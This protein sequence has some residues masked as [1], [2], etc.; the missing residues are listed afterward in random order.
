[1]KRSALDA[2]EANSLAAKPVA[3]RPRDA[4]SLIILDRSPSGVRVLLG[5]RRADLK[6]MPGQFV[7]P[8][9]RTDA[10]DRFTGVAGQLP[11]DDL[12]KLI[13]GQGSGA[14]A[15]RSH[16]I[17]VT[18]LRE[19]YEETGLM[20]GRPAQAGIATAIYGGHG[21]APD[22]STL[23]YLARAITPPGRVRRF[24]TRFFA[25]WRDSIGGER[26]GGAPDQEFS[27]LRWASFAETA[28]LDCPAITRTIL[29]VIEARLIVDPL[30]TDVVAV[31]EYRMRHGRFVCEM[32]D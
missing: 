13:A 4:A 14:S 25:V 28:N 8:G 31:P 29:S 17:G 7:F 5:K 24:D 2:L 11:A 18:A 26:P 16:A 9:G 10:A 30:L 27:E 21:V 1:M 6:F 23:R 32:R 3:L 15:N 12:R 19:C 20:V 22:L